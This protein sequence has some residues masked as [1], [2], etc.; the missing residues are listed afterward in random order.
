MLIDPT[1]LRD[2]W[3]HAVWNPV[4]G[5][6][7]D[8]AFGL[9][10]DKLDPLYNASD[11]RWNGDWTF[12]SVRADGTWRTLVKIP[13]AT[14]GTARPKP[15]DRWLFNLGRSANHESGKSAD[16]L[17]MLWCPNLAKAKT[18]SDPDAMGVL[19]FCR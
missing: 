17:L 15:G 13:Y 10:T 18:L 11:S 12:R 1:G 4:D 2:V 5:S 6:L 16:I 19:E 14:I 7:F 3:Y 8:A 9:I